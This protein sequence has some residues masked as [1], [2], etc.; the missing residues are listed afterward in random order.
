MM[1]YTPTSHKPFSETK[2]T[3]LK[4]SNERI[5]CT[6][7]LTVKL[8][9]KLKSFKLKIL[10]F[11]KQILRTNNEMKPKGQAEIREFKGISLACGVVIMPLTAS[12]IN[13]KNNITTK[14]CTCTNNFCL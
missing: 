2:Q 14:F 9:C 10:S 13:I 8:L 6:K 1:Q 5:P 11:E 12:C 7:N 3:F 4:R